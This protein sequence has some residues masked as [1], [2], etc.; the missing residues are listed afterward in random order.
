[1]HPYIALQLVD[2]RRADIERVASGG[3]RAAGRPARRRRPSPRVAL[4]IR[5]I[6]AGKWLVDVRALRVDSAC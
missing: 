5:L 6:R 1:M 4:G 3:A 2:A